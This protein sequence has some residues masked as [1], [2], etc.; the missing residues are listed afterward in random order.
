MSSLK[1]IWN[2]DHLHLPKR[3]G[4]AMFCVLGGAMVGEGLGLFGEAGPAVQV[5]IGLVFLVLGAWFTVEWWRSHKRI[6]KDG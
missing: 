5:V 6:F 2:S 1:K 4:S 3:K